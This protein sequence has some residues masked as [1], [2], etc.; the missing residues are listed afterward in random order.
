MEDFIRWA[1]RVEWDH[2][3]VANLESSRRKDKNYDVKMTALVYYDEEIDEEERERRWAT[4]DKK[5]TYRMVD[6][7]NLQLDIPWPE[8]W[9]NGEILYT[10]DEWDPAVENFPKA[11]AAIQRV[12]EICLERRRLAFPS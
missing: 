8:A 4:L 10:K 1:H 3:I 2:I 9:H 7:L 6:I 11:M 5:I 12:P